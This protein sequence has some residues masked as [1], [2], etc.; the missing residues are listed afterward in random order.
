MDEL[1]DFATFVKARLKRGNWRAFEF[2]TVSDPVAEMLNER[3]YFIVKGAA[4]IPENLFGYFA[5]EVERAPLGET[6][7]VLL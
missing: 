7:K 3:G 1:R 2:G 6:P 4:P 5:E